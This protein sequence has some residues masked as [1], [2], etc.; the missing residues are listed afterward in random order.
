MLD[1]FPTHGRPQ[2]AMRLKSADPVWIA[3]HGERVRVEPAGRTGGHLAWTLPEGVRLET[4]AL[5]R[6]LKPVVRPVAAKPVQDLPR[7]T[8]A[9]LPWSV[10]GLPGSSAASLTDRS[11]GALLA[12]RRLAVLERGHV[13]VVLREQAFQASGAC[14]DACAARLGKLLGSDLVL[15]GNAAMVGQMGV[16]QAR[17]V[18][19]STGLVVNTAT[20]TTNDGEDAIPPLVGSVVQELAAELPED[21]GSIAKTS[22]IGRVG[23]P[24]GCFPMGASDLEE[25]AAPVHDVC[26][27]PFRIDPAEVANDAYEK[28]VQAGR[29]QPAH[30]D[31]GICYH[32]DMERKVW[33]QSTLGT[34]FRDPRMPV[35][36][37]QW[38]QAQD[39]CRFAKGRLPTEAEWEFAARWKSRGKFPWGDD[40]EDACRYGN[41]AD[42]TFA[43]MFGRIPGQRCSDGRSRMA[44]IA[45]YAP[46]PNGLYDMTGNAQEWTA[47]WYWGSYYLYSPVRDPPGAQAG[48][49]KVIRGGGWRKSGVLLRPERRDIADPLFPVD[50]LGFR[51]VDG[52]TEKVE[53]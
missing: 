13:D 30:Y 51:C 9:V 45:Q 6:V 37:V 10:S 23:L 2:D 31:D 1:E 50:E 32:L 22:T 4:D 43:D 36:C 21:S 38:K 16:L 34:D 18:Q 15:L 52:G 47:D 19:S 25:D 35:V 40:P 39:Y 12:T 53:K 42:R 3:P 46:T 26:V 17:L 11:T 8:V 49:K 27:D 33:S 28:C 20:A 24:G 48:E 14:E 44:P 5:G 29:C 7:I 41:V